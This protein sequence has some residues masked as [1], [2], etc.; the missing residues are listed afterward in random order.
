[1]NLM[2]LMILSELIMKILRKDDTYKETEIYELLYAAIKNNFRC[3]DKS[4]KMYEKEFYAKV[5]YYDDARII[6]TIHETQFDTVNNP[7]VL[8]HADIFDI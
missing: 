6:I 1:M 7:V 4:L 5:V 2:F 3:L 8:G